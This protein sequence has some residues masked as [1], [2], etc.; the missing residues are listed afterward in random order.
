MSTNHYRVVTRI[1]AHSSYT[2]HLCIQQWI[3]AIVNYFACDHATSATCLTIR[4]I[5]N[6]KTTFQFYF[7][8]SGRLHSLITKTVEFFYAHHQQTN[9]DVWFRLT[10]R[11][12]WFICTDLVI[13]Q[14]TKC[15]LYSCEQE[16][17]QL[18]HYHVRTAFSEWSLSVSVYTSFALELFNTR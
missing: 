14:M 13:L 6:W 3:W 9:Q 17:A 11:I 1:C 5:I 16:H 4:S 2:G 15:I 8:F 18:A 12:F 7:E 10:N